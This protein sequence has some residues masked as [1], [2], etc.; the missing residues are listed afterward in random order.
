LVKTPVTEQLTTKAEAAADR[1]SGKRA[2]AMLRDFADQPALQWATA[3]ILY[4]GTAAVVTWPLAIHLDSTIYLSPGRPLGDYTG[5]IGYLRELVES[6]ENPFLPGTLDDLN[7]PDGHPLP[8]ALNL[9]SFPRT[10]L[11]YTLAA[12]FG[13]VAAFGMYVLAGFT[14]SGLAMFAFLRTRGVSWVLALTFGWA[15]AFY[16]FA[17]SAGEAP[18]HLHGWVFVVMG[19]RLFRLH[20]DP[21]VRN[22][23]WAGLATVL[24]LAWNP[25]FVLLGGVLYVTAVL[26]DLGT[27]VAR[28]DLRARLLP[29]VVA[30]IPILLFVAFAGLLSL[31]GSEITGQRSAAN[32]LADVTANAARPRYYVIP[33][34][35][36]TLWSGW[37]HEYWFERGMF[38]GHDRA[39]YVGISLLLL[40]GAAGIAWLRARMPRRNRALVLGAGVVA[41][42]AALFSGP[43]EVGVGG[44]LLKFPSYYVFEVTGSWRIF[45]RFVIVVMLGL[46]VLAALG[47]SWL[48]TRRPTAVVAA[49]TGTIAILVPLDLVGSWSP[50]VREDLSAPKIYQTVRKLPPGIVVEYPIRLT[51]VA[52]DYREIFWQ[53]AHGKPILNGY[54]ARGYAESR[55]LALQDPNGPWTAAHLSALGVKYALVQRKVALP[56]PGIFP[57]SR[58]TAPG[59][60]H[61]AS[62]TYAWLY[63]V[64]ARP[65][66]LLEP[67]AGWGGRDF[68][69]R[70]GR[71]MQDADATMRVKAPCA[72]C[73]GRLSFLAGSPD[74]VRLLTIRDPGGRILY[75]GR[76]GHK[77]RPVRLRMVF[78]RRVDLRFAIEPGPKDEIGSSVVVR[79]PVVTLTDRPSSPSIW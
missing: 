59:Y 51:D 2:K 37:S 7:A 70:P 53:N 3:V 16:P 69:D 75:R 42:T 4:L 73:R 65:A 34:D 60:Q 74:V 72:R 54:P 25:Y 12:L 71:A 14:A 5:V 44:E 32:T 58:P 48:T 6:G 47:A 55:A 49:V 10:G 29:H 57:P 28:R 1:S 79:S 20:E 56:A 50:R 22:G 8:W 41:A 23:L 46:C 30:G 15:F 68:Y 61:I 78:G 67:H 31:A 21:T 40:S 38:S 39:L 26:L 64:T 52:G 36:S 35:W 19:W 33:V 24:C 9:L 63:R 45:S 27:A 13:P 62:D 77:E 76:V 66:T 18:D 43:P 11:L 17:L